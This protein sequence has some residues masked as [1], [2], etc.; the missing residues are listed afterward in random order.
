MS[1][2]KTHDGRQDFAHTH[3][4]LKLSLIAL[5]VIV[6]LFTGF[7]IF[8]SNE[9]NSV[10]LAE[11]SEKAT[12]NT[13]ITEYENIEGYSE[14]VTSCRPYYE[15]GLNGS[16][17][18]NEKGQ[19][20]CVKI[21]SVKKGDHLTLSIG[22]FDEEEKWHEV[23]K[24]VSKKV[25]PNRNE[26]TGVIYYD[27]IGVFRYPKESVKNS[28]LYN[29]EETLGGIFTIVENSP[30]GFGGFGIN[31][32]LYTYPQPGSPHTGSEVVRVWID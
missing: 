4:K 28:E 12:S 15:E 8:T 30:Y 16:V 7:S 2:V 20:L 1:S 31:G 3:K 27:Y 5:A 24:Y 26:E 23:K 29:S 10:V 22:Y 32:S 14:Y 25:A 18:D 13:V 17:W 11:I 6:V 21:I 19:P 9:N